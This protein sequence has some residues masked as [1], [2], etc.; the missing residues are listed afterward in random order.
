MSPQDVR[1]ARELTG[2]SNELTGSVAD[3]RDPDRQIGPYAVIK[4]QYLLE[5]PKR[6]Q[7]KDNRFPTCRMVANFALYHVFSKYH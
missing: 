7:H 5:K 3:P 4:I 6:D 1:M 2:L